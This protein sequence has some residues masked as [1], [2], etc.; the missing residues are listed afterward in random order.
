MI[1]LR[2]GMSSM[3]EQP[4][5]IS[6]ESFHDEMEALSIIRKAFADFRSTLQDQ[7]ARMFTGGN[8]EE[9][10]EVLGELKD[11]T[12]DWSEMNDTLIGARNG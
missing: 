11:M 12:P 7:Q 5:P 8:K 3:T 4:R 1:E 2:N 9:I 10:E 6:D